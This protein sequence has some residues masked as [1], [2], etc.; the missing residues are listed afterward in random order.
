MEIRIK[1]AGELTDDRVTLTIEATHHETSELVSRVMGYGGAN[2]VLD[3][4]EKVNKIPVLEAQLVQRLDEINDL[5]AALTQ[6]EQEAQGYDGDRKVMRDRA[7]RA[8]DKAATLITE[9]E[10]LRSEL[11]FRTQQ[12]D[13]ASHRMAEHSEELTSR[14]VAET[15]RAEENKGWAERA[16]A[17][18]DLEVERGIERHQMLQTQGD[19]ILKIRQLVTTAGAASGDSSCP[20]IVHDI[21]RLLGED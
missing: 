17:R 21:R 12:A 11:A 2:N 19:L 5:R 10:R 7:A 15:K 4:W 13:T 8:A 16:E 9:N 20:V 3:I 14:L 1:T 18:F 6:A